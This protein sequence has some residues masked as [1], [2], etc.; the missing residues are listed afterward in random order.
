M[1]LLTEENAK[2]PK[3]ES[4]GWLTG[5]LYLAPADES[6]V[7]NT[8]PFA[9]LCKD[10][11][12]FTSG[13]ASV[14]TSVNQARIAKTRRLAADREGFL[15]QLRLDIAALIRRADRMGL[16][17]AVRLNG[18]SDLPWLAL[19][20]CNEFPAVQFYDYTKCPK[21]WIRLRPNYHI[22]F[23]LD[24]NRNLAEARAALANHISVA[25]V[26][27]TRKGH[28]LPTEWLGRPVVDGDQHDLRFL[29]PSGVVVGLRAK[30][31]AIHDA[32]GFVQVLRRAT[33]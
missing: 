1:S 32:S 22:T 30:G 18:T 23:S 12:L 10:P 33:V 17:P 14:F 24:G 4:Y 15:A 27:D 8:C 7:I 25:V 2:T 21:P 11:C 20:L 19:R 16:R 3:G 31:Q 28:Q 6:G 26:F 9:G 29:D 5:I 13:R